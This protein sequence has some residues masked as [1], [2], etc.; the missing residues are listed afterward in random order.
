[1]TTLKLL[2]KEI[3][4]IDNQIISLLKKRLEIAQAIGKIKKELNLPIEDRKR[5]EEVL[6]RAGEFREIFEKI[7]EVSKDVQRL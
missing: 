3:D 1:M 7:L 5:E 6:R 2:R 4:K